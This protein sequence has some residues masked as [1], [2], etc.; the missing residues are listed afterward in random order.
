M[1]LHYAFELITWMILLPASLRAFV[2][3]FANPLVNRAQVAR[4][5]D[6]QGWQHRLAL[7]GAGVLIGGVFLGFYVSGVLMMTV[8]DVATGAGLTMSATVTYGPLAYLCLKDVIVAHRGATDSWAFG[9]ELRDEDVIVGARE[10]AVRRR[11]RWYAVTIGLESAIAGAVYFATAGRAATNLQIAA[12]IVVLGMATALL[13]LRIV[14][15]AY[16]VAEFLERIGQAIRSAQVSQSG[17]RISNTL[18]EHQ[19]RGRG[20]GAEMLEASLPA[21]HRAVQSLLRRH[22]AWQE[23]SVHALVAPVFADLQ[24]VAASGSAVLPGTETRLA[25]RLALLAEIPGVRSNGLQI[26][27]LT[28]HRG[29]SQAP[30]LLPGRIDRWLPAHIAGLAKF[31]VTAGAFATVVLGLVKGLGE[32]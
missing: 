11:W 23:D 30:S 5:Q 12:A 26:R 17:V 7:A 27:A 31:A 22:P 14:D 18:V 20:T 8:G 16:P 2:I 6:G 25:I 9:S 21:L 13:V 3:G 32:L 28:D 19:A 4:I 1:S 10:V 24:R 15:M 29:W